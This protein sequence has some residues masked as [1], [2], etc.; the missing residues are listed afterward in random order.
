[1]RVAFLNF[2]QCRYSTGIPGYRSPT[3]SWESASCNYVKVERVRCWITLN[4]FTNRFSF[5]MEYCSVLTWHLILSLVSLCVL[6]MSDKPITFTIEEEQDGDALIGNLKETTEMRA[7]YSLEV[8]HQLRFSFLKS[9][10]QYAYFSIAEETG[11]I[12]TRQRIDRETVCVPSAAV[13]SMNLTVMIKPDIY[14]SFVKV[15]VHVRD[16]NDHSPQFPQPNLRWS[17]AETASI[18]S[19]FS[20]PSADDLDAGQNG[21]QTY[22]L[23]SRSDKFRLDVTNNSDGSINV[24]LVLR[25]ALDRETEESYLLKLVAKDGGTPVKSGALIIDITVTD[26]NDNSPTFDVNSYEAVIHEN[27][28]VRTTVVQVHATDPDTGQNGQV[29]YSL[30]PQTMAQFGGIFGIENQTGEVYVKGTIDYEQTKLYQLSIKASDGTLSAFCKV[31]IRVTDVNDHTP[32]IVVDTLTGSGEAHVAENAD[33]A[34]FV[35]HIAV[36]D[37][38]TGV[39]GEIE[40]SIDDAL[41]RLLEMSEGVYKLVT[42]VV[43]DREAVD[44]YEVTIFCL[45]HGSPK[46]TS[47]SVIIVRIIDD[48]DHS[49]QLNVTS[50]FMKFAENNTLGQF[51]IQVNAT[52]S[53][54]GA[55]GRLLYRID[56]AEGSSGTMLAIGASSG[57]VTARKVF[58]YE[59]KRHYEYI[60]TVS[61]MAD[62]PKSVTAMLNLTV[63]DVNDELPEF[64]K[65]RYNFN[66]TENRPPRTQVGTVTA[67]DG[68]DTPFNKVL[69]ALDPRSTNGSFSINPYTGS[70]FTTSVLDREHCATYYLK[71]T[72]MNEGYSTVRSSVIATVHILD[73]NDNAPVVLFPS[74]HNNTVE[75]ADTA[76]VG[77]VITRIS[78]TDP[79]AHSN[80]MLSYTITNGNENNLFKL[81]PQT[82]AVTIANDI[83]AFLG[84]RDHRACRLVIVVKDH[85]QPPLSVITDLNIVINKSTMLL[86]GVKPSGSSQNDN[87]GSSNFMILIGVVCGAICLIIAITIAILVIK[88]RQRKQRKNRQY[89]SHLAATELNNI[90]L[91]ST[92]NSLEKTM[93]SSGNDRSLDADSELKKQIIKKEV[94]FNFDVDGAH[95]DRIPVTWP[96]QPDRGDVQVRS[97]FF[98]CFFVINTTLSISKH[99]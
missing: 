5:K 97:V 74:R 37:Q 1:M 11:E 53:D 80:G 15:V 83:G 89:N 91:E 6:C 23:I 75:I 43:F 3:A 36:D 73:V 9:D 49:P 22:E 4:G 27:A 19:K 96:L 48:N 34:T 45:D 40:C 35:A 66:I 20:L 68:D 98:H 44:L 25:S 54:I 86:G 38:D 31:I 57:V 33:I 82:G 81:D 56:D 18:G 30:A 85:G 61:D 39:N 65:S 8:L 59:K 58:D 93:E 41:F 12:R 84:S 79:D 55:N 24:N 29:T 88:F 64:N 99:L 67:T 46:E 90:P 76:S 50:Y 51:V 47:S 2:G 92:N 52:D 63:T 78:A 70:I 71:V 72:A 94:T 7:K 95:V 21:I 62:T 60:I 69:F 13:C 16:I 26:S 10:Q 17:F 14:F 77:S 87:G 32:D 42:A 28:R